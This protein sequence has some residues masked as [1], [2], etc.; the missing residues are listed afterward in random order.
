MTQIA[1]E[2]RLTIPE[3]LHPHSRHIEGVIVRPGHDLHHAMMSRIMWSHSHQLW[4]LGIEDE[5]VNYFTRTR[6]NIVRHCR[7][8][9]CKVRI[10][11]RKVGIFDTVQLDPH[12]GARYGLSMSKEAFRPIADAC[13][14]IINQGMSELSSCITTR[15]R[16]S[17]PSLSTA[18]RTNAQRQVRARTVWVLLRTAW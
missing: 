7:L 2:S 6:G 16:V 4:H 12:R 14:H 9:Y 15:G 8:F 5:V 13:G 10:S 1:G 17:L 3:H 18:T 11:A